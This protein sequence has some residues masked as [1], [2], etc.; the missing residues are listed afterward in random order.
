MEELAATFKKGMQLASPVIILW[1]NDFIIT[2][3]YL[4]LVSDIGAVYFLC[5]PIYLLPEN[6]W[7]DS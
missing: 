5:I 6:L 1:D 3:L 2:P 4:Y 7:L